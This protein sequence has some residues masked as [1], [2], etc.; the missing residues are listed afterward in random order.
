MT[1]IPEIEGFI[2]EHMGT[3]ELVRFD[4]GLADPEYKDGAWVLPANDYD[5]LRQSMR[6]LV[7]HLGENKRVAFAPPHNLDWAI[8]RWV[9]LSELIGKEID[10]VACIPTRT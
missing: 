10:A 3:H 7:E 8:A 4:A 5:V 2:W 1:Q 9:I 6:Y